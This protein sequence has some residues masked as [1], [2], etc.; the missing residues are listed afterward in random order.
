MGRQGAVSLD[1]QTPCP[2][3]YPV[4]D[5]Y[6]RAVE[7]NMAR[8]RRKAKLVKVPPAGGRWRSNLSRKL[9]QQQ[10]R[11]PLNASQLFACRCHASA[12]E[13]CVT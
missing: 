12:A 2:L 5:P 8:A 7:K 10:I 4:M 11:H 13:G 9:P 6:V 3:R 1:K